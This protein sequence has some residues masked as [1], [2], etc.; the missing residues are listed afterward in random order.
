MRANS[1]TPYLQVSVQKP[2]LMLKVKK[3]STWE[4]SKKERDMEKDR[5]KKMVKSLRLNGMKEKWM[6]KQKWK[7]K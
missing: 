6:K 3:K 5:F 4:N 1:Y 2:L 7:K